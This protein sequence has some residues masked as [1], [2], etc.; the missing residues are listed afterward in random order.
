MKLLKGLQRTTLIAALAVCAFGATPSKA[1]GPYNTDSVAGTC[2]GN[3]GVA[4]VG[5]VD[6]GTAVGHI[7]VS[8]VG[9]LSINELQAVNFGN[10]AVTTPAGAGDGHVILNPNGTIGAVTGANTDGLLLLHGVGANGGTGG[11]EAG[12]VG[13][14]GQHP[15]VYA[16]KGANEGG[17]TRVYISFADTSG[18]PLDCNGD[19]YY[20]THKVTVLGPAAGKTF[21]VDTFVFDSTAGG[22]TVSSD[23]YGHYV[24][25][26]GAGPFNIEVG[27]TL[28][29][30]AASTGYPV[31]KYEGEFNITASY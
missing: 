30:D 7:G 6:C 9:T 13:N 17:Q 25:G 19:T 16:I 8:V 22:A 21:L 10:V 23:V 29:T 5:V 4:G 18:N 15:G 20:P 3:A 31:G 2:T 27:A 11:G 24:S 28:S 26:A 14:D 1:A 12:H